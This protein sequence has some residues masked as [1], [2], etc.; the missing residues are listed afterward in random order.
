VNAEEAIAVWSER[1][2]EARRA[3]LSIT[4]APSGGVPSFA[5]AAAPLPAGR[6][7]GEGRDRICSVANWAPA[8]DRVRGRLFAGASLDE[9]D[10]LYREL[11]K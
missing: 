10:S 1:E 9:F 8:P 7:P 2:R 11:A 3:R 6:H 5:L 4:V